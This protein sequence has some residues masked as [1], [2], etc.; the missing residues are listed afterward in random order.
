MLR[1]LKGSYTKEDYLVLLSLIRD[2]CGEIPCE[3]N[4]KECKHRR[5]CVDI[6]ELQKFCEEELEHGRYR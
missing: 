6:E 5:A 4:C 3:N 1:L 2:D